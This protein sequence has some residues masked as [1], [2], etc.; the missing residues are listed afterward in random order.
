MSR[1]V[2][3]HFT[4]LIGAL[5]SI[6]CAIISDEKKGASIA[7]RGTR[8]GARAAVRSDPIIFLDV[9]LRPYKD[10]KQARS[11]RPRDR[12]GGKRGDARRDDNASLQAGGLLRERM[13]S[14][15]Q[16]HDV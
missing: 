15:T 2:Q 9:G 4:Y 11:Y 10:S 3:Y 16:E 14:V 8:R 7:Q 5:L 1:E 6:S 13:G 12:E